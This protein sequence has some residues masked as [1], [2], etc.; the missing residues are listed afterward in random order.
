MWNVQQYEQST[1]WAVDQKVGLAVAACR[2]PRP[3]GGEFYVNLRSNLTQWQV[4]RPVSSGDDRIFPQT[5]MNLHASIA[6][7]KWFLQMS[8][9]RLVHGSLS[10]HCRDP[11]SSAKVPKLPA[12]WE[13]RFSR[14]GEAGNSCGN[15]WQGSEEFW[16]DVVVWCLK[17]QD[18]PNGTADPKHLN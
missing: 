6:L 4:C 12:H 3:D 7:S 8:F 18:L 9:S 13:E 1:R 15:T 11:Q 17:A 5:F 10:V 14:K 16:E 2:S